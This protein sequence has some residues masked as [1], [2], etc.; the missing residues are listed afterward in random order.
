MTILRA[1]AT[2]CP[3]ASD[4]IACVVTS[5]P[6]N[7][8]VEYGPH[9]DDARS[10]GEYSVMA[11]A[12][13]REMFRVLMPGGRAWINVQPAVPV[14]NAGH[15][16]GLA[17]VWS[18]AMTE[19]GFLWRDDVVWVQD[20]HDGACAW[21]SWKSPSAPNL[22]GGYEVIQLW[23]KGEWKRPK[24]TPEASKEAEDG[25]LGGVWTDLV[26]NVWKIRPARRR[27]GAPAPFPIELPARCIRLSTWPGETVLDSFAG[28]GTTVEAASQLGR[29]GIGLDLGA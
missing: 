13:A 23:F 25:L 29:V 2:N 14:Q 22:R 3:L 4:S 11:A 1:D 27:D 24:P 17:S 9:Y 12:S 18:Q 8:G 20:S 28:S 5:P 15:R 19:A 6:Y 10:W 21:G 16:H 7:C 26:R